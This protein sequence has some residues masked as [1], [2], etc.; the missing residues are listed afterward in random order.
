[1][2]QLSNDHKDRSNQHEN[3]PKLC[4]ERGHPVLSLTESEWKLRQQHN[5]NLLKSPMTNIGRL[6]DRENVI[7]GR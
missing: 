4:N 6:V 1:M 7:F 2:E 3:S 5:Q